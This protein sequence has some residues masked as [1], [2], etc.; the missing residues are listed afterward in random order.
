MKRRVKPFNELLRWQKNRRLR[1]IATGIDESDISENHDLKAR[2][3][4]DLDVGSKEKII[5]ER[6]IENS[7]SDLNDTLYHSSNSNDSNKDIQE[8]LSENILEN[9]HNLN[10]CF[11]D[12]SNDTFLS[13]IQL[14]AIR[15]NISHVAV[16]EL[17][18]LYKKYYPNDKILSD[19]RVFL[20]TPRKCI[21]KTCGS[22]EYLYYG[23]QKALLENLKQNTDDFTNNFITIDLNIDRLPISKSTNRQLWPIQAKILNFDQP[24]IVGIY[25]GMSKPSSVEEFLNEYR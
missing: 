12:C 5:E 11:A 15:N 4:T 18:K 7:L 2:N 1:L 10:N 20:S 14:W 3:C 21:T 23:L 24:F 19:A 9:E 22:R 16:S 8:E 6:Q 13:E 17:L 25:H